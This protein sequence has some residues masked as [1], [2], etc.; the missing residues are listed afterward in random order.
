MQALYQKYGV[1]FYLINIIIFIFFIFLGK[2]TNRCCIF[3]VINLFYS[4]FCIYFRL[5]KNKFSYIYQNLNI[6]NEVKGNG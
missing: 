1:F 6:F 4:Y 2:L 5:N 3:C